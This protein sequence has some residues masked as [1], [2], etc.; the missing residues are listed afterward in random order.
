M[1]REYPDLI[2]FHLAVFRAEIFLS[3]TMSAQEFSRN[4][5]RERDGF[6]DASVL[7]Q[8][9]FRLVLEKVIGVEV[10]GQEEEVVALMRAYGIEREFKQMAEDDSGY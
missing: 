7:A 9:S 8:R 4:V 2:E 1:V 6:F 5:G 3:S 10:D